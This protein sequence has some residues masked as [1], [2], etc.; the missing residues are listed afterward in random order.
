MLSTYKVL[1]IH[2]LSAV[3]EQEMLQC[4]H[5]VA[6]LIRDR[7]AHD[8]DTGQFME[9]DKEAFEEVGYQYPCLQ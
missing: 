5:H 7:A 2:C 9:V 1:W 3:S 4:A 6:D 8:R